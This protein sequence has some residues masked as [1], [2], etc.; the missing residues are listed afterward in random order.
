VVG[1]RWLE[2][3]NMLPQQHVMIFQKPDPKTQ[4]GQEFLAL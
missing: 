3:K 2:T 1:L 4:E